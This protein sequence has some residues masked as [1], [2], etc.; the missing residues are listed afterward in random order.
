MIAEESF[1]KVKL[2]ASQS[3]PT[4]NQIIS[5]LQ[6]IESL[7]ELLPELSGWPMVVGN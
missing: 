4:W 2:L 7:R 5:W 3:I 1:K 6:E